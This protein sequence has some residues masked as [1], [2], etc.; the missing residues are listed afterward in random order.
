[1][2]DYWI[3]SLSSLLSIFIVEL[4]MLGVNKGFRNAKHRRLTAHPVKESP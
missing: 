3:P 1:M 4:P 2:I